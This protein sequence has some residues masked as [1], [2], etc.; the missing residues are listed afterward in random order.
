MDMD[1]RYNLRSQKRTEKIIPVELQ[2][3]SDADFFSQTVGSSH[4]MPRQVLSDHSFSTSASDLDVSGLLNT[5]D[6]DF[7]SPDIGSGKHA[8]AGVTAKESVAGTSR[9]EDSSQES[10]NQ[11]IL[12]QL[13][14]LGD[15]LASLE[16]KTTVKSKKSSDIRKIKNPKRSQVTQSDITAQVG[17]HQRPKVR[18][19]LGV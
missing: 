3:A 10:I 11:K 5:S 7:R 2:L 18:L 13:S 17:V 16:Q 9:N 8:R 15:R 12:A 14:V 4:P 1:S 6:C 19:H